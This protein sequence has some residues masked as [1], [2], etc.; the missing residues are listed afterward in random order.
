MRRDV[1]F[2]VMAAVACHLAVLFGFQVTLSHPVRP[3]RNIAVEVTLVAAPPPPTA[4]VPPTIAIPK[5]SPQPIRQP[6]PPQQPIVLPKPDPMPVAKP[7][8]PIIKVPIDSPPPVP[9]PKPNISARAEAT[10]PVFGDSSPLKFGLDQTAMLAQPGVKASPNY[11]KNPEP[12]Y[13]PTARRRHQEGLVVLSVKVSSKGRSIHAEVK[14]GSGF[15][16]LDEAALQ[17]VRG[18]EFE[19]ARIGSLAIESE[20]EVPIRFK[21][22]N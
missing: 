4:I 13:P 16:V 7:V 6:I 9:V 18:W 15:P 1:Q 20:I 12:A 17:A 3:A 21:L 10:P 2:S 19:P 22:A 11:L 8:E 14:Q 5:V